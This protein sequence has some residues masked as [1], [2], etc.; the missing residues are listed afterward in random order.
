M[1]AGDVAKDLD[2]AREHY[3][4]AVASARAR[5]AVDASPAAGAALAAALHVLGR[6]ELDAGRPKEALAPLEESFKRSA[7]VATLRHF[8]LLEARLRAGRDADARELLNSVPREDWGSTAD[9][10]EALLRFRAEGDSD[11][12]REAAG[13]AI[14]AAPEVV[15]HLVEGADAPEPRDGDGADDV[16]YAWRAVADAFESTEGAI[17]W[18][19]DVAAERAEE[20]EDDEDDDA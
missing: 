1:L 15:D 9:Y 17:E 7:G 6:A 20:G 11:A 16:Y 10:A 12:A 13:A 5:S 19:D 3:G 14:D 18:I 8:D 2:V 4:R